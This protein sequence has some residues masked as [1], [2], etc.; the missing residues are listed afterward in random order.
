[1]RTYA[2]V[3]Q[4]L[5]NCMYELKLQV[6]GGVVVVVVAGGGGGGGGGGEVGFSLTGNANSTTPFYIQLS[7]Y[8]RLRSYQH[9]T[10]TPA[11]APPI[12]ATRIAIFA[13]R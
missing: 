2:I 12:T 4:C 1:M 11:S 9:P 3:Y 5:D 6:Y 10:P 7:P 8:C 13:P